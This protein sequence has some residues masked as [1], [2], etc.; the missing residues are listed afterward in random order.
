[1][2]NA[3][4]ISVI[5]PVYNREK[6][7]AEAVE[8]ILAQ[9]YPNIELICIDDGSTD[10]SDKILRSFGEKIVHIP[11]DQNLGIAAARNK[12]IAIAQGEYLALMDDDDIATPD[13]LELQ[14]KQFQENPNLDISFTF[15]QCF[16]SPELPEEIKKLRFCP[17][18]PTS[19]IISGTALIK[20]SSFKKVGDFDPKWKVGEFVDWFAKAQELGLTHD[21]VSKVCLHRRIHDTNVGVT[22][23]DS[24]TDYL[25]I[26]RAA[27]NRRKEK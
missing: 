5:M 16:I 6:Y 9:T 3:P 17:P 21:M 23:R 25:K 4:L 2:N 15:I 13:R 14:M 19:G 12:G 1:M 18:E 27:L 24:R 26:V 10:S 8:S 22:D 11:G 7:V 20:T